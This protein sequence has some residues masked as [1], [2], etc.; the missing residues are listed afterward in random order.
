MKFGLFALLLL[1]G[2]L[3]VGQHTH[4]ILGIGLFRTETTNQVHV[5]QARTLGFYG[6][7]QR[8]DL[9]YTS[10]LTVDIPTNSN[11][12]LEIIRKP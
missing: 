3:P 1:T 2:C 7:D 10:L 5:V 6:G 11:T 4:L 12:L 8:W 9:G